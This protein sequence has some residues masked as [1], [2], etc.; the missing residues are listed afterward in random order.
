MSYLIYF[1]ILGYV[2]TIV[3]HIGN[4]VVMAKPPS[5]EVLEDVRIRNFSQLQYR[6][7]TCWT[8]FLQVVYAVAALYC[9]IL[10][11]A[12]SKK[13]EYKLPYY[14]KGFRETLFSAIVWPSS[15]VV[16]IFFWTLFT[17]DR[18][19]VFP[20]YLDKALKPINN[21]IMH[22]AILPIVLWE[23]LFQPRTQPRSHKR[24]LAHLV[25]HF[26]LYVAVLIYTYIE[27]GSWIYPI[28]GKLYGTAYLPL[29]VGFTL[30]FAL[31]CYYLQW[32]LI[33]V[34][35]RTPGK[36]KKKVR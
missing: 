34:L 32:V 36:A 33:S 22:T 23:L 9:D 19:L 6:Y 27:R 10:I 17:Y 4:M 30:A 3:L 8:F 24:Y 2:A 26:G 12:N 35:W 13:K 20:E 15:L 28:L 18:S 14:L 31:F 1:R 29:L 16:C 11:L 5:K 25:F 7:L 21:H